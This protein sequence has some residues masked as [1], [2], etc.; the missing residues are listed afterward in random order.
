MWL[1]HATTLKFEYVDNGNADIR[2]GFQ[3]GDGHW[4]YLGKEI[5]NIPPNQRT[6]NF[7][8]RHNTQIPDG[9]IERVAVHE[10][11]HSLGLIHEQSQPKANID[12]D[13][14]KVY[15]YF[16]RTQ[17]WNRE[18][19][20]HNVLERYSNKIT[21]YSDYDQTSIMHYSFPGFLLKSGQD[22]TGGNKLS[23]TDKQFA[24]EHWGQ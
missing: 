4:S 17:G 23:E 13:E 18:E 22:I 19:T 24:K 12:W 21:Q 6:M 10:I 20:F 14:D 16:E 8:W 1:K 2:V 3:E 9:E 11:G 15:E 5:R 7:G